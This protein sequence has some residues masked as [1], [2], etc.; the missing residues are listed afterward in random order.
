MFTTS[1]SSP[2]SHRAGQG[3]LRPVPRLIPHRGREADRHGSRL[4]LGL[5][6]RTYDAKN[7]Q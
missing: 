2:V 4:G 7:D 6:A 5:Q 3:R 1:I